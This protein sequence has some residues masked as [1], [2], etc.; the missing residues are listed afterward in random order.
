MDGHLPAFALVLHNSVFRRSPTPREAA[1]GERRA[2]RVG[3]RDGADEGARHRASDGLQGGGHSPGA[4]QGG[5]GGGASPLP[6][7]PWGQ[8]IPHASQGIGRASP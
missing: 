7:H 5:L 4:L 3:A 1:P 6:M 8:G 2:V